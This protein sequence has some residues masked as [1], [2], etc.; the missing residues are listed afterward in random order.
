M[1]LFWVQNKWFFISALNMLR[2]SPHSVTFYGMNRDL[3]EKESIQARYKA[4]WFFNTWIALDN[5]Q[6]IRE[7]EKQWYLIEVTSSAKN[8]KHGSI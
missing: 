5:F 1:K 3:K 4:D 8:S 7:C 6:C 2:M